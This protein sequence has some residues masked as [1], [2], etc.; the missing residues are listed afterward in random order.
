[1]LAK[2]RQREPAILATFGSSIFGV[3]RNACEHA[4]SSHLSSKESVVVFVESKGP[5]V[6]I[7]CALQPHLTRVLIAFKW[8]GEITSVV[9][10][11]H[12]SDSSGSKKIPLLM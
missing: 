6:F 5:V 3:I 2:I 11:F 4:T 9:L 8:L 1:M 7:E 10:P 12:L